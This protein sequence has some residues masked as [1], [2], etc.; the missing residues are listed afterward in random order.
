MDLLEIEMLSQMFSNVMVIYSRHLFVCLFVFLF[1]YLFV[2]IIFH[3][4]TTRV[5][6]FLLETLQISF[7][8]Y[9]YNLKNFFQ[10]L[11][12]II[13]TLYLNCNKATT[14]SKR[15]V[16]FF[17]QFSFHALPGR[18]SPLLEGYFTNI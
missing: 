17:S 9:F 13:I 3:G 6:I 5:H 12:S 18:E 10:E 2:F 14:L 16:Y 8:N 11:D 1:V 15:L 7:Q 4:R